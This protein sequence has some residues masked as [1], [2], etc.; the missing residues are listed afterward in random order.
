M[1]PGGRGE[2]RGDREDGSASGEVKQGA[3]STEL[4]ARRPPVMEPELIEIKQDRPGFDRFIG[5]W[6]CLFDKTMVVDV[7]PSRSV[8]KL[9]DSLTARGVH[10]VDFVLL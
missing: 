3:W 9:I 4:R 2:S 10:R 7:G 5:S 6:L 8:P 1:G